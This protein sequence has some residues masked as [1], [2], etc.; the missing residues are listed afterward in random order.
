MAMPKEKDKCQFIKSNGSQCGLFAVIGQ[1]YCGIH[2]RKAGVAESLIA[3]PVTQSEPIHVLAKKE[4]ANYQAMGDQFERF[5]SFP[6]EFRNRY[7]T[8]LA[9]N[10]RESLKG[11]FEEVAMAKATLDNFQVITRD[12]KCDCGEPFQCA[13]CGKTVQTDN[14]DRLIVMIDQV[15]KIVERLNRIEDGQKVF[16]TYTTNA[17]NLYMQQLIPVIQTYVRDPDDLARLAA[18]VE[19]FG[20]GFGDYATQK[21]GIA[22]PETGSIQ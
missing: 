1:A 13:S 12:M 7:Q 21:L 18:D 2:M 8:L 20:C 22:K 3:E 9:R 4:Q 11:I 6:T 15:T 5:P 16:V 19:R 14:S 17:L 10:S